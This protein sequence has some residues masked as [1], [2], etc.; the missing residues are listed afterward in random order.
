M[1]TK[2]SQESRPNFFR[3]KL[4]KSCVDFSS[5]EGKKLFTE[6]LLSGYANIYFKL[7]AQF[8]TQ[9]EPAYCGISTLVMVLNAL[10]VDPGK[11]W[12]AP[13]RFYHET[14]LQC[15]VPLDIVKIKGITLPQ[16]YCLAKCNRLNVDLHYGDISAGDISVNFLTMLREDVKKC[17]AS[18]D[19]ILVVSFDRATLGQTGTGHFSPIG[20]Y[21]ETSDEVLIMDV[22]RFKYPPHWV[23]LTLLQKA[24]LPIDE[25]TNK[26]RGMFCEICIN[27]SQDCC[28]MTKLNS[29]CQEICQNIQSLE[30][31]KFM[32][33]SAI[34]ALL[35]SWPIQLNSKRSIFLVDYLQGISKTLDAASQNEIFLLN[36]QLKTLLSMR[37]SIPNC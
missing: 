10:D 16:F 22:A 32:N 36:S 29:C 34:I 28:L 27:D 35:L 9:E 25:A 11:I 30:I 19:M 37:L 2:N 21:N 26:S 20:A 8:L 18:D 15:C 1:D 33:S 14:M 12:K 6:S 4:P 5:S 23:S 13:W 31:A 17:V 24:M 3:R 7:A